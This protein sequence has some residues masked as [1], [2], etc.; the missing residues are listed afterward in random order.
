MP[1]LD[2]PNYIMDCYNESVTDRIETYGEDY[3][4]TETDFYEEDYDE[5]EDY[6][7]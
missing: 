7:P 5:D 4:P 6:E 3:Y 1:K 2:I